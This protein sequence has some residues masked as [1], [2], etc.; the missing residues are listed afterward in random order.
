MPPTPARSNRYTAVTEQTPEEYNRYLAVMEHVRYGTTIPLR[1]IQTVFV[2]T[3]D[4]HS[5]L[6]E[7]I[8]NINLRTS[9]QIDSQSSFNN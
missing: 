8:I 6:V 9:S 3:K 5:L 1:C 7:P 4:M 2:R